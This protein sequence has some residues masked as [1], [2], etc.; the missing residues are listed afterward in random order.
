MK[1]RR[2]ARRSL[3]PE[4][5]PVA[6]LITWNRCTFGEWPIG[7]RVETR[8]I[9][10]KPLGPMRS[11]WGTAGICSGLDAS[12]RY[13]WEG[14]AVNASRLLWLGVLL[15]AFFSLVAGCTDGD[16]NSSTDHP[17]EKS[18]ADKGACEAQTSIAKNVLILKQYPPLP[19]PPGHDHYVQLLQSRCGVTWESLPSDH[20]GQPANIRAEVRA[21]NLTMETEI[22]K[23]FGETILSDLQEQAKQLFQQSLS[24]GSNASNSK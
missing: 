7:S 10:Q 21:W 24:G 3:P 2:F 19:N 11:P 4:H 1:H 23:R 16:F 5:P 18:S 14:N 12:G 17:S 15:N 20:P 22:R 6:S 13:G 8:G 9:F